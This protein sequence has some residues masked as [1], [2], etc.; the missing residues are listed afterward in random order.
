MKTQKSF[1]KK[2]LLSSVAMLL[3]AMVALGSATFAWFTQS[4]TATASG[5]VMKATASNG[6]KILTQTHKVEDS[7]AAYGSSD[8]LNYKGG[9]SSTDPVYLNPASYT[10]DTSG[11]SLTGPFKTTAESDSSATAKADAA[12][13]NAVESYTGTL[14]VYAEEIYCK[15]V[16]A[17]D[18]SAT[19]TLSLASL[20][21]TTNNTPLR[22]ALRVLV[23]YKGQI[24]GAYAMTEEENSSL[25]QTGDSYN[26]AKNDSNMSFTAWT[27]VSNVELGTLGQTGDDAVKVYIYLD[28]EDSDCYSQNISISDIITS[29]EVNLSIPTT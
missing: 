8:Y 16:G 7:G 23:A 10:F 19:T 26:D 17:A 21:V 15:L 18:T 5:L 20:N 27:N 1:R 9:A 29:V 12:V 25:K 11:G 2:A 6:L 14:D 4:P 3:V 13:S 22:G 28:G 24:K